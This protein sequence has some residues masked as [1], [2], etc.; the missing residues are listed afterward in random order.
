MAVPGGWRSLTLMA[1]HNRPQD[2]QR[3]SNKLRARDDPG[4]KLG[5]RNVTVKG[6]GREGSRHVASD[7]KNRCRERA[8]SALGTLASGSL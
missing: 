8:H 4:L 2:E 6:H 1:P 5:L 3:L 7:L